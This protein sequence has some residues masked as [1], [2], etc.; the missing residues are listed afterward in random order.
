MLPDISNA[1]VNSINAQIDLML[2]LGLAITGG[3]LVTILQVAFH[4]KKN[5]TNP[6]IFKYYGM[7]IFAFASE[8]ASILFGYLSK[9]SVTALIPV[10]FHTKFPGDKSLSSVVFPGHTTLKVYVL[11]QFLFLFLGIVL[12]LSLI[13]VNRKM[14]GKSVKIRPGKTEGSRLHS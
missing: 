14:L 13:I 8:A 12:I 4:N 3:I 10:I 2:T 9:S 5:V 7:L 11:S 1:I 6:I